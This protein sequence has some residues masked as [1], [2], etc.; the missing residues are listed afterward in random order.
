M[1]GAGKKVRQAG[2]WF[3]KEILQSKAGAVAFPMFG[4]GLYQAYKGNGWFYSG[5]KATDFGA[6]PPGPDASDRAIQAARDAERRRML[7]GSRRQ[8]FIGGDFEP[9]PGSLKIG[10]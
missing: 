8:S 1:G 10:G 6:P 3:D 5:A 2:R 4:T 9:P 7:A